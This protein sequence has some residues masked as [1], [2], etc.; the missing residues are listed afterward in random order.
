MIVGTSTKRASSPLRDTTIGLASAMLLT[1]SAA[2]ASPQSVQLQRELGGLAGYYALPAS[3]LRE[4]RRDRFRRLAQQWS[5][6]T[7]WVSSTTQLAMHPAYQGIIGMGRD[8]LPFILEELRSNS[9]QWYWAL[10]AISN[11]DPVPPR[12]RGLVKRMDQ[13]W[14]RWGE[15]KGLIAL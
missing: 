9:G 2:G 4:G 15:R 11:E 13:A 8:V 7:R 3:R 10:K 14:L 5:T 12:D 1:V 6:E